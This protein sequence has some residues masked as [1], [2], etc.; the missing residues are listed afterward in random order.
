MVNDPILAPI[1]RSRKARMPNPVCRFQRI[2]IEHTSLRALRPV[3]LIHGIWA[4]KLQLAE[5]II[6]VVAPSRA[7]DDE[8]LIRLGVC[9]LFRTLVGTQPVVYLAAVWRFLPSL[10][11]RGDDLALGEVGGCGPGVR[12]LGDAQIRRPGG[13][14]IFPAAIDVVEAVRMLEVGAVDGELVVRIELAFHGEVASPGVRSIVL[15]HEH[16]VVYR[17]AVVGAIHRLLRRRVVGIRGGGEDDVPFSGN[18][19][20]FGGPNVS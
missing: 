2:L 4:C 8:C 9:E 10:I 1:F 6:P 18:G 7:V 17:G 3:L 15:Q 20:Q 16:P 12:E 13:V 14:G 11:R 19:V 5:A